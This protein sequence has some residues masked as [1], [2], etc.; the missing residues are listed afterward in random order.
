MPLINHE[1]NLIFTWSV[2][3]V[4]LC[5]GN[6]NQVATI[7]INHIKPSVS[8]VTSSTQENSKLHH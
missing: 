5:T 6:A 3:C 1:I 2:N 7:E 8:A 4:I